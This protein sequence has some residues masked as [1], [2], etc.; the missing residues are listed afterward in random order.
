M[1]GVEKNAKNDERKEERARDFLHG[2]SEWMPRSMQ[3]CIWPEAS[4]ILADD[5]VLAGWTGR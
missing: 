5:T 2:R 1:R 4:I 3:R